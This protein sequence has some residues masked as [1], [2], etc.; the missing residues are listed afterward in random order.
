MEKS[1]LNH[2]C[3]KYGCAAVYLNPKLHFFDDCFA[4]NIRMGDIDG[5][6]ERNGHILW[7]EWKRGGVIDS[8]EQQ[9]RAQI[10]LAKAFTRNSEKQSFVFVLG[11]PVAM[12]VSR[13]RVIHNGQWRWGWHDGGTAQF[14][15][16]LRYW[17]AQA[18]K[19][20]TIEGNAA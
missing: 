12:T 7:L 17:Y 8:F 14:K 4:G 15:D 19:G 18:D 2:A 9:H 6:V 5:A 1:A 13:F 16:F 20:L 3:E 11:D 10:I